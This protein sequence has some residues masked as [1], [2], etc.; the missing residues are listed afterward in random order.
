MKILSEQ[1]FKKYSENVKDLHKKIENFTIS[2]KELDF[3]YLTEVSSVF[4]S[5]IE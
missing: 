5:N 2:T 3:T 1:Y 4:S